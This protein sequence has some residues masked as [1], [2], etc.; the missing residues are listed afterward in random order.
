MRYYYFSASLTPEQCQG[1]YQGL[2]KYVIVTADN[3]E[4]VQLPFR[5]F[6]PF[7][8]MTGIRGRFRLSLDNH[9]NFLA[10]DKIN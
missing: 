1:F 6:L 8:S 5:H 10:L 4:R 7:I 9:A 2:V 3:G